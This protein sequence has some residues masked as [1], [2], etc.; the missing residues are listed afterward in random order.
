MLNAPYSPLEFAY[1][2]QARDSLASPALLAY[3]GH[4]L[5]EYIH[6]YLPYLEAVSSI[7]NL[8]MRLALVTRDPLNMAVFS[9][10]TFNYTVRVQSLYLLLSVGQDE[11]EELLK[12]SS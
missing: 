1:A 11:S 12:V 10:P 3:V 5:I 9:I 7:C 2:G 4:C 6:R 8:R